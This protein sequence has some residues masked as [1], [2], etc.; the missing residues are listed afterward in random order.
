MEAEDKNLI[1]NFEKSLSN[2]KVE[3]DNISSAKDVQFSDQ[4]DFLFKSMS[5]LLPVL[6][7]ELSP[8]SAIDS[9]RADHTM[10]VVGLMKHLESSLYK[11][12]EFESREEVDLSHP[13][14]Q[15]AMDWVIEGVLQSLTESGVQSDVVTTFVHKLGHKMVGFEEEANKRLKGT[16]FS[17]L[18]TLDNPLI[19]EF[20]KKRGV[21]TKS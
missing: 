14:I 21:T 2:F 3:L 9:S 18:E 16:S 15:R 7:N 1:L 19:V 8:G 5:S 12:R 6:M 10:K 4:I 11:K 20:N 17:K 13:K